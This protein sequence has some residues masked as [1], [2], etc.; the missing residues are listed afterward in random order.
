MKSAEAMQPGPPQLGDPPDSPPPHPQP[1]LPLPAERRR[2]EPRYAVHGVA[3]NLAAIRNARILNLSL[4]GCAVETSKY[5][6]IGRTYP[7]KLL[8]EIHVSVTAEAVWCRLIGTARNRRTEIEPVYHAGF[9]FLELTRETRWHL[10]K[11]LDQSLPRMAAA[12]SDQRAAHR[13]P[14]KRTPR[15]RG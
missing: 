9:E 10:R 1:A 2:P 12:I 14:H 6:T 13:T 5:L 11:L 4:T 7:L 8:G 3:G 15:P